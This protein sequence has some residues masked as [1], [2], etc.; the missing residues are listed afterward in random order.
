MEISIS[1]GNKYYS[2]TETVTVSR[3]KT[4]EEEK[5]EALA[6]KEELRIKEYEDAE[7]R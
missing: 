6:K 2:K 1:A 5:A 3:K 7:K 4:A